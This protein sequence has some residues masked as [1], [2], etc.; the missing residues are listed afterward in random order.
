MSRKVP[1]ARCVL[2]GATDDRIRCKTERNDPI[3][4][5]VT[6]QLATNSIESVRFRTFPG[7]TQQEFLFSCYPEK[8]RRASAT[9]VLADRLTDR[10]EP[11]TGIDIVDVDLSSVGAVPVPTARLLKQQH[12]TVDWRSLTKNHPVFELLSRLVARGDPHILDIE[13]TE[14]T[15]NA[16]AVSVRYALFSDEFQTTTCDDHAE[17]VVDGLPVSL[18][19]V[20]DDEHLL[21]N[22]ELPLAEEWEARQFEDRHGEINQPRLEQEHAVNCLDSDPDNAWELVST[23]AE[24]RQLVAAGHSH[25]LDNKYQALGYDPWIDIEERHLSAILGIAPIYYDQETSWVSCQ[26]HAV[27]ELTLRRELRSANGTE[28][29]LTE[30]GWTDIALAAMTTDP[31]Q[32]ITEFVQTTNCPLLTQIATEWYYQQGDQLE[33]P[34]SDLVEAVLSRIPPEGRAHSVVVGTAE[35]LSAGKLVT[36]ATQA[37]QRGRNITIVTDTKSTAVWAMDQL[38]QPYQ[39]RPTNTQW[40]QLHN[41]E[42]PWLPDRLPLVRRDG[43]KVSWHATFTDRLVGAIANTICI[44]VD[45]ADQTIT[46]LDRPVLHCEENTYAVVKDDT[47]IEE[48]RD[49]DAVSD[50]WRSIP[51]PALPYEPTFARRLQA[52]YRS[53]SH[54]KPLEPRDFGPDWDTRLATRRHTKSCQA[55]IQMLTAPAEGESIL[56]EIAWSAF[57]EWARCQS[58]RQLPSKATFRRECSRQVTVSDSGT[59]AHIQNRAWWYP[60]GRTAPGWLPDATDTQ[61]RRQQIAIRL[62]ERGYDR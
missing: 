32:E 8:G 38:L 14:R 3:V 45:M 59:E 6:A 30:S 27:P 17:Y 10:L 4:E 56:L 37:A 11:R 41:R 61:S 40:R 42:V 54:L 60:F 34:S 25:N 62:L 44:D 31:P 23:S 49:L 19:T 51:A 53:N 9:A 21:S 2:S 50:E 58:W 18:A 5:A 33:L 47:V 20:F 1:S 28:R 13:I 36:A 46:E 16:Y 39:K 26:G 52:C 7:V 29:S 35:T 57:V 55:F 24:F 48:Y 43:G 15:D 12:R 22:Y